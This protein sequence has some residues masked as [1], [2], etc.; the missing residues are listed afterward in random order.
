MARAPHPQVLI[1]GGG[2]GGIT[3]LAGTATNV[4]VSTHT[5]GTEQGLALGSLGAVGWAPWVA[6]QYPQANN[7]MF[8]DSYV[9]VTSPAHWN[10]L[11][12][13]WDLFTAFRPVRV[14][15]NTRFCLSAFGC[16]NIQ[17]TASRALPVSCR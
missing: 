13:N 16:L 9:G 11:D 6:A 12:E 15:P 4:L 5:P 2:L 1:F 3:N 14:P 10:T 17:N 8:G 7:V